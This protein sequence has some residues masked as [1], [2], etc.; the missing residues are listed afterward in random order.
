MPPSIRT[1]RPAG[2]HRTAADRPDAVGSFLGRQRRLAE[3]HPRLLFVA[4]R[5][6]RVDGHRFAA[7]AVRAGA[8]VRW[9]RDRSTA[10]RRRA[11]PWCRSPDPLRRAPG[12]RRLVAAR[13][14]P[15]GWWESPA[16]PARRSPRRSSPTSCSRALSVLRNEGNLN[17]RVRPPDDPAARCEPSARGGGARDGMYAEGEIARLAEIARP[18]VGV[19][20]GRAP[21]PSP[22]RGQHRGDR[23]GQVRAPAALPRDGLAVLN[24]DDPRVAAMRDVT[25]AARSAPSAWA[26]APTSAPTEIDLPRRRGHRV[27]ARGSPWGCRRLRSGDP[28]APPGAAC[29]GR[30]R[31]R[32]ALRA[33]P[34]DEVEAALAAGSRAAHRMAVAEAAGG[35]TLIDDT[36]NASPVACAAALDF[37]AE[38][39]V[40]AGRARHAVLG[41][42]LEL[43]PDEERLH[44]EIGAKA[45]G[46]VDGAAGGRRPRARGSPRAARA[47]GL[48]R[49]ATADDADEARRGRS[50][51]TWRRASATCCWSRAR[52]GSSSTGWSRHL[53]GAPAAPR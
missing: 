36:Y 10:A 9:W 24:A 41:D 6:E 29:A 27:H 51:A 49:V 13:E 40:P 43:G 48:R 50:S 7:D 2:R 34:L 42:M 8:A 17:S 21:N 45:A 3:D 39:P 16:R 11:A 31:R 26:A 23:A 53:T 46:I 12:P 35:A 30:S 5:G 37:L 22:A 19:V 38:T 1:R 4:L 14:A 44:R 18:E 28:G 20:A 33:C 52:A 47:A 32:R 25:P 15:F